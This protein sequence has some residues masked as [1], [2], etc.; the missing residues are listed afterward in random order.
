M[1]CFVT[2][3]PLPEL[4]SQLAPAPS[5]ARP[6]SGLPQAIAAMLPAVG[7]RLSRSTADAVVVERAGAIA[8]GHER[9]A[10][11]DALVKLAG[12]FDRR[13]QGLRE[14]IVFSGALGAS[15]A[16]HVYAPPEEVPH[17]FERLAEALASPPPGVDAFG[18]ALV[19]GYY[20][21]ALHPFPGGNGRWSRLVALQA[22]THAGSPGEGVIAAGFMATAN[23]ALSGSVW[24]RAADAGLQAYLQLGARYRHGLLAGVETAA[25]TQQWQHLSELLARYAPSRRE[26]ERSL[27]HIL[28]T[29]QLDLGRLRTRFA[30]S[31]KRESGL[32]AALDQAIPGLRDR[33][34]ALGFE[35]SARELAGSVRNTSLETFR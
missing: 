34:A 28:A 33:F 35:S 19:A 18:F 24:P 23:A 6:L 2:P 20:A 12:A 4:L 7:Q 14:D 11:A 10:S 9:Y 21:S 1:L 22:A 3:L 29:D 17:H 30:L 26:L 13:N 15:A 16:T 5:D 27:I 8:F 25:L 32:V 31:A